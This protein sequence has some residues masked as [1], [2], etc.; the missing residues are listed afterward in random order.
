MSNKID[1]YSCNNCLFL[2]LADDFRFNP[3]YRNSTARILPQCPK[4]GILGS[5]TYSYLDFKD[6][7]KEV[8]RRMRW[9]RRYFY[10]RDRNDRKML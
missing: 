10:W 8:L 7:K 2:G 9:E 6:D 3:S 5:H 1:V 4:C